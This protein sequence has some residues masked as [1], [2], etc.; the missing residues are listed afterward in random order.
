MYVLSLV[1][2]LSVVVIWFDLICS[3]MMVHGSAYFIVRPFPWFVKSRGSCV[4]RGGILIG[5]GGNWQC[6]LPL[7]IVLAWYCFGIGFNRTW[8]CVPFVLPGTGTISNMPEL[9]FVFVWRECWLKHGV[10]PSLE[11]MPTHIVYVPVYT[12]IPLVFAWRRLIC[13]IF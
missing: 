10:F 2:C 1:V 12:N 9:W 7:L 5:G 3:A 6:L 4:S 11:E 8:I 13:R